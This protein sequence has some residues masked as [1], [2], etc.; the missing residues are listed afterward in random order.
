ML[1]SNLVRKAEKAKDYAMQPDRIN[2][3]QCTVEFR[4]DNNYH[5][6]SFEDGKWRCDCYTFSNHRTCSHTMAM[7]MVLEGGVHS[8]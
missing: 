8:A 3:K 6:V 4:G 2:L 5:T 7:R 1:N